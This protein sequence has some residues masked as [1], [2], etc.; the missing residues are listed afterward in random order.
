MGGEEGSSGRTRWWCVAS[1]LQAVVGEGVFTGSSLESLKSAVKL[2]QLSRL[3]ELEGQ[4]PG[5]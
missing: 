5:G 4:G 1:A 3:V 2:L